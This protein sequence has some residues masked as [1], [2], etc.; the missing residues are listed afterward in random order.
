MP[1]QKNK[2]GHIEVICGPMFSGK[3]EELIRRITRIEYTK[4][5]IRIFKPQTD[6][7]YSK[8]SI[9]SHN[10]RKIKC[11]L[12]N[13]TEDILNFTKSTDIFA[14]DESQFFDKSIIEICLN[15]VKNNK[16]VIVAGLDR[17]SNAKPFGS[18]PN[19]LAHA[20][21]ITKLNAICVKCGDIATF[22][23]RIVDNTSQIFIGDYHVGGNRELQTLEREG[24][25]NS[26]LKI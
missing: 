15:L 24:K 18:M 8:D 5:V 19:I 6:N 10:G 2:F 21:Y 7:R 4:K 9:V 20:D 13:N 3:T 11:T 23:Y 17:D 26:I 14:F 25:L 1:I 22:S 16:R 12:V